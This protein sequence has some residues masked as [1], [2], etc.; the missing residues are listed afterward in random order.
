[1]DSGHIEDIIDL[2]YQFRIFKCPVAITSCRLAR[3]GIYQNISYKRW[4]V[5]YIVMSIMIVN[6]RL[7]EFIFI[8]ISI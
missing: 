6:D 1:M 8:H 5:L 2:I 7:R 4:T 3:Q